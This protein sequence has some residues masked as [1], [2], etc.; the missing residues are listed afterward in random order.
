[1]T[2]LATLLIVGTAVAA[3]LV[4]GV[5][6]AADLGE[7]S[8][9]GR[10][11]LIALLPAAL[12]TG[13][14]TAP[15]QEAADLGALG[16]READKQFE[17]SARNIVARYDAHL[18][19]VWAAWETYAARVAAIKPTTQLTPADVATWTQ[20]VIADRDVAIKRRDAKLAAIAANRQAELDQAV[21]ARANIRSATAGILRAW[22][23]QG[24][25]TA[26]MAQALREGGT[27]IAEGYVQY[28]RD[29]ALQQ[30][31]EAAAA[32]AAAEEE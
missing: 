7:P 17:I 2:V 19:S 26:A 32:A 20:R 4:L 14:I 29:K 12:L 3:V 1:M 11:V 13:C 16:D 28:R 22:A 8:R 23:A 30:Q 25:M 18:A 15:P 27:G 10:L 31:A 5:A 24:K 6:L 9:R 21:G